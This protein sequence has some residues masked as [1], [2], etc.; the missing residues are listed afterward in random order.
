MFK[1][2]LYWNIVY[3]YFV[4]SI[5]LFYNIYKF[6]IT[7]FYLP[8]PE[9]T[10][11]EIFKRSF[12]TS[13]KYTVLYLFVEIMLIS[14][15]TLLIYFATVFL[16]PRVIWDNLNL[17]KFL[18][19]FIGVPIIVTIMLIILIPLLSIK[20]NLRFLTLICLLV[21]VVSATIYLLTHMAE[22]Q[23]IPSVLGLYG[24]FIVLPTITKI[25]VD[26]WKGDSKVNRMHSM[27]LSG[28]KAKEEEIDD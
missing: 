8:G 17:W 5:F 26:Y 13:L 16:S 21:S 2:F 12:Q 20:F 11:F 25:I 6:L 10:G 27:K 14:I 15:P 9:A 23:T 7:K 1:S 24:Q 4:I 18:V 3:L 28:Y 19:Y 22:Y